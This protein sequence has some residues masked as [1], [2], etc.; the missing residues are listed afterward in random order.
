[1]KESSWIVASVE[2]STETPSRLN[3]IVISASTDT[4]D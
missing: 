1:M 3:K 4:R 2:V